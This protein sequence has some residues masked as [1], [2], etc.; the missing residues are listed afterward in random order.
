MSPVTAPAAAAATGAQLKCG[1]CKRAIDKTQHNHIEAIGKDWHV[2]CFVCNECAKPPPNNE[3]NVFKEKVF[4]TPCYKRK[5]AV[6]CDKCSDPIESDVFKAIGKKFHFDCW[7]CKHDGHVIAP[8]A[9]FNEH[10][11]DVYC[12]PHFEQLFAKRCGGCKNTINGA[13]LQLGP[14]YF[15]PDCWKCLL[16]SVVLSPST[17]TQNKGRFVCKPCNKEIKAGTKTL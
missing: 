2:E 14:D 12:V 1:G 3:F 10:K 4:C 6:R 5:Y 7:T 17:A 9:A 8:D 11:G 15:H 16:C 13:F